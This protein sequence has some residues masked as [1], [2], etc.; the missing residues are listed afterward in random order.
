MKMIVHQTPRVN[1][2]VSFLARLGQGVQE[3]QPIF[4]VVKDRLAPVPSIHHVI[5]RP[6]I[7]HS[8]FLRHIVAASE[9]GTL[10]EDVKTATWKKFVVTPL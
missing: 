2:P 7:L 8:K 1:L 4:I 10:G 6:R 3:Q 5:N 9:R